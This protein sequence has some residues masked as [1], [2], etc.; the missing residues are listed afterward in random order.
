MNEIKV[1][2]KCRRGRQQGECDCTCSKKNRE[3][4]TAPAHPAYFDH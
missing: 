2:N 1:V 4:E 3:P